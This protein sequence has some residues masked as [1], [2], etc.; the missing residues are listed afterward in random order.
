MARNRVNNSLSIGRSS[1]TSHGCAVL[2]NSFATLK[3]Q[4]IPDDSVLQSSGQSSYIDGHILSFVAGVFSLRLMMDECTSCPRFLCCQR[5][6]L[7][8]E[9]C[10]NFN[11]TAFVGWLKFIHLFVGMSKVMTVLAWR[12]VR[13]SYVC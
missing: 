7:S 6:F 12:F 10:P 9:L 8:L 5:G 4:S 3:C 11:S 2:I 13:S 1:K